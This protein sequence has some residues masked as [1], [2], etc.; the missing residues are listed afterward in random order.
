M[1]VMFLIYSDVCSWFNYLLTFCVF[2]RMLM[3]MQEFGNS[4]SACHFNLCRSLCNLLSASKTHEMSVANSQLK[5][6]NIW[7]C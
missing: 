3:N 7:I 2:A 4:L 6:D 5:Q 1:L